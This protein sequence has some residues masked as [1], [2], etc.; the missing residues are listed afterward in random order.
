MSL[1]W[2]VLLAAGLLAPVVMLAG[3]FVF[4]LWLELGRGDD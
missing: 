4:L 3:L 2:Y 1:P